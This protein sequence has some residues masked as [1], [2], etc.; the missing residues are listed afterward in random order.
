MENKILTV[1][2]VAELLKVPISWVYKRTKRRA[3]DRLPHLKFGKYVRFE[4]RAILA[5]IASQRR[6]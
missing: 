4:E 6:V 5:Y 1:A 2:Q 3:P